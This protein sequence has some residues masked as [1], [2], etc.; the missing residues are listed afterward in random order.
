MTEALMHKN[1]IDGQLAQAGWSVEHSNLLEEYLI[2]TDLQSSGNDARMEFN[3]YVLL[4]HDG[5]PIAVVE[6]KRSSRD[7]LAG[8]R[9]GN[10]YADVIKEKFNFDPFIFLTNGEVNW[11]EL[12]QLQKEVTHITQSHLASAQLS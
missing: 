10:N 5:N 4:N 11:F 9:Q 7:A 12:Q 2:R 8:K 1:W 3:D 6:A